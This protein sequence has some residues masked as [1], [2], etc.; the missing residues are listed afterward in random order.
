MFHVPIPTTLILDS[1]TI[2]IIRAFFHIPMVS[3]FSWIGFLLMIST[4]LAEYTIGN[5]QLEENADHVKEKRELM[6]I[7]FVL[8]FMA[9]IFEKGL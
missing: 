8:F 3:T 1:S 6:W 5:S 7:L 4:L 2:R 9:V